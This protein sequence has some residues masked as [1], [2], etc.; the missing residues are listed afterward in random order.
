[1]IIVAGETWGYNERCHQQPRR[2]WIL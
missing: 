2:S 1:M